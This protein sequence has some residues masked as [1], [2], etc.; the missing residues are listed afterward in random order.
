MKTSN[1]PIKPS[2]SDYNKPRL[3][4]IAAG[5]KY[6]EGQKFVHRDL[7]ARNILVA[8]P[9][10][11]KISD[12]GLSRAIKAESATYQAHKGGKWPVKWWVCFVSLF[13]LQFLFLILSYMFSVH[14]VKFCLSVDAFFY[15][16]SFFGRKSPASGL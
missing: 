5:M 9:D 10:M 14:Y 2:K 7:A 12:F 1:R 6:L 11:V 4:Q 8:A 3:P 15:N 13:A 16:C